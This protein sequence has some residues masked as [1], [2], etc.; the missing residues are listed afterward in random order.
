LFTLNQCECF[1]G[2]DLVLAALIGWGAAGAVEAQ[3]TILNQDLSPSSSWSQA[4]G[5]ETE[6]VISLAPGIVG[7]AGDE[8]IHAR[9]YVSA[10]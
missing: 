3:T 1:F 4:F 9:A 5:I 8:A 2:A 10:R 6:S 7:I